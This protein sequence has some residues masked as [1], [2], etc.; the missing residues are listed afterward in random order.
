MASILLHHSLQ[1]IGINLL[2]QLAVQCSA[3]MEYRLVMNS[4]V[5]I[6]RIYMM[7]LQNP[8]MAGVLAQHQ[9]QPTVACPNITE[10]LRY[11]DK[12]PQPS[13][14]DLSAHIPKFEDQGY[15]QIDQ[16]TRATIEQLSDWLNIGKGIADLMISYAREDVRLLNEGRFSMATGVGND[17]AGWNAAEQ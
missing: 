3:H 17:V 12:H 15:R 14:D 13:G 6:H 10:W 9:I 4:V 11:C 16:I 8:P 7:L 5:L 2:L 1:D